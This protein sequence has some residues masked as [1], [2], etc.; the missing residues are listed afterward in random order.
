MDAQH[1]AWNERQKR[2]QEALANSNEHSLALSL[3]LHQH[4]MLHAQAVSGISEPTFDDQL[5]QGLDEASSR[6]IPPG[7]E[8]SIAWCLWHIA[9]IED[10]TMN[11]L[12]AGRPQ[13][14]VEE[15]WLGRLNVPFR[16]TGNAQ[17]ADDTVNLSATIDLPNLRLYRQA[18]GR[19]TREIVQA[20]SPAA[21]REKV[22]PSRLEH[23]WHDEAVLADGRE[24]VEYWG[25]R[26]LAGLL[27]MPATRHPLVHVNEAMRIKELVQSRER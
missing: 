5:W 14:F 26:T 11:L 6:C 18:V 22:Q 2:L 25:G 20:L 15:D 27:L 4:A 3:F 7:A 1:K 9:R 10:L 13:L 12:A 17:P 23:I 16:D 21:L 19:R 8:H 24:V